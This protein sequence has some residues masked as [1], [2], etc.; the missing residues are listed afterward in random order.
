MVQKQAHKHE[1]AAIGK[2]I[3]SVSVLDYEMWKTHLD[4]HT[5]VVF[6]VSV[7]SAFQEP[8]QVSGSEPVSSY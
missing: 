6:S 3:I 8:L 5:D 2:D 1:H 7:C 4:W